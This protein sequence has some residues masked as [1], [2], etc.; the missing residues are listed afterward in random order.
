MALSSE[1]GSN[2]ILTFIPPV[3]NRPYNRMLV[4]TVI[5]GALKPELE[6]RLKFNIF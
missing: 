1:R 3:P 5:A 2:L 4:I 6:G